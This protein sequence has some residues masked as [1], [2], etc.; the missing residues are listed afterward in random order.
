MIKFASVS[1]YNSLKTNKIVLIYFIKLLKYD[2]LLRIKFIFWRKHE[3]KTYCIFNSLHNYVDRLWQWRGSSSDSKKLDNNSKVTKSNFRKFPT[4]DAKL[5]EYTLADDGYSN[6]IK[7]TDIKSPD[8]DKLKVVVVPK[9][10]TVKT[11]DGNVKK[12]VVAVSGLSNLDK[13]EAIVLPNTVKEIGDSA[14]VN[15]DKLRFVHLGDSV[16]KTGGKLFIN[17][18][19]EFLDIPDS[20]QHMG[21]TLNDVTTLNDQIAQSIGSDRPLKYIRIPGTLTDFSNLYLPAPDT[22]G[23]I[24]KTPKG[25][26]GEKW[27]KYWGLKVEYIK[28]KVVTPEKSLWGDLLEK[29]QAEKK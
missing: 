3:K 18:P 14:F 19:I 17:S 5:F 20:M 11:V 2:V 15:N 4:T 22:K 7:I 26:E 6:H 1:P 29:Q 24:V 8:D 10:I 16:E 12:T 23:P 27:A 9:T 25:S 28:G 21:N 13:A